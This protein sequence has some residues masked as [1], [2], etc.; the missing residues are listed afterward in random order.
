MR[1]TRHPPEFLIFV[2]NGKA[3]D[4]LGATDNEATAAA[5][6]R[7]GACLVI[8]SHQL[9]IPATATRATRHQPKEG[10]RHE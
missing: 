7:Q 10:Q 1:A 3:H 8:E 5:Y 4:F 6:R 2:P 9:F